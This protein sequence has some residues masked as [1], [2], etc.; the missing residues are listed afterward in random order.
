MS[1]RVCLKIYSRHL[2]VPLCG[3]FGSHLVNVARYVS[4]IR[5]KSPT[6]CGTHLTESNFQT[7]SR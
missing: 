3:V 2:H 7:P 4:L 6:N 1:A 5:A